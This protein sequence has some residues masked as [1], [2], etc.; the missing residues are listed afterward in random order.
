MK[1]II[2]ILAAIAIVL[3]AV[4]IVFADDADTAL[5]Q[6][7]SVELLATDTKYRKYSEGASAITDASGNTS[8]VKTYTGQ[9][10]TDTDTAYGGNIF[11]KFNSEKA[12]DAT[13]TIKFLP[14]TATTKGRFLAF[15]NPSK[16]PEAFN[17]NSAA[18]CPSIGDALVNRLFTDDEHKLRGNFDINNPVYAD[19]KFEVTLKAGDNLVWIPSYRLQAYDAENK[20]WVCDPPYSS[21]NNQTLI[22][23][24]KVE[25]PSDDAVPDNVTVYAKDLAWTQLP[26]N[27]FNGLK[28]KKWNKS[29]INIAE[30]DNAYGYT[31]Y[32]AGKNGDCTIFPFNVSK[33]GDYKLKVYYAAQFSSGSTAA[34]YVDANPAYTD[35]D[36]GNG[37][38][39]GNWIQN[40][41]TVESNI[42]AFKTVNGSTISPITNGTWYN[43][44]NSVLIKNNDNQ[45][46]T[47]PL[48]YVKAPYF[49]IKTFDLGTLTRGAHTASFLQE[50]ISGVAYN[51]RLLINRIE[52]IPAK[53]AKTVEINTFAYND[54]DNK[55]VG[56]ET[57]RPKN[58]LYDVQTAR[59]ANKDIQLGAQFINNTGAAQNFVPIIAYYHGNQLVDAKIQE[60][61]A[62]AAAENV[63]ETKLYTVDIASLDSSVDAIKLFILKDD[64]ITPAY[65]VTSLA[66]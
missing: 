18:D 34:V 40:T 45:S 23:S 50:D 52:I 53:T 62:L 11:F 14:N 16:S 13:L 42:A 44:G 29:Y 20:K 32:S 59:T 65:T 60:K 35:T 64:I 63:T 1:K 24:L 19:E 49:V 15:L 38:M 4:P 6:G 66:D 22:H 55:T 5:K 43:T 30:P 7:D 27:S 9:L 33:T 17:C 31:N 28:D 12:C 26:G 2:C 51:K 54:C 37:N 41:S 61:V 46:E 21:A 58:H 48:T 56:V 47:A 3:S 10:K 8:T 57:I 39:S 36:G 25:I